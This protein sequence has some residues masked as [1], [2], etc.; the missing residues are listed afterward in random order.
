M[1]EALAARRQGDAAAL[2]RLH[3]NETIVRLAE[4]GPILSPPPASEANG[5]PRKR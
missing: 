4:L 1:D 5:V 2:M 3:L